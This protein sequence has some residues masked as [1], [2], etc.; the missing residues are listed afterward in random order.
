LL[1][2][3][4]HMRRALAYAWAFCRWVLTFWIFVYRAV[5]YEVFFIGEIIGQI[6]TKLL[7]SLEVKVEMSTGALVQRDWRRLRLVALVVP[8]RRAVGDR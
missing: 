5:E 7:S 1:V 4:S 6:V 3:D 8:A 2:F